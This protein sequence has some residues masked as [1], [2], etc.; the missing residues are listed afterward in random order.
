MSGVYDADHF[1][2][3]WIKSSSVSNGTNSMSFGNSSINYSVTW[4]DASPYSASNSIEAVMDKGIKI[5]RPGKIQFMGRV[6]ASANTPVTGRVGL[7]TS[8]SVGTNVSTLTDEV[9]AGNINSTNNTTVTLTI[10]SE[11]VGQTLYVGV[12]VGL[13]YLINTNTSSASGSFAISEI[14]I[15]YD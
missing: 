7:K 13:R 4:R 2:T 5:E 10:P 3:T 11:Y 14:Q 1:T 6:T 12:N 8:R 15:I 9:V